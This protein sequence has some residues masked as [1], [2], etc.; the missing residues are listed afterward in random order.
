MPTSVLAQVGSP[1]AAGVTSAAVNRVAK[2]ATT[3]NLIRVSVPILSPSKSSVNVA[4]YWADRSMSN[5]IDVDF[6]K[7]AQRKCQS[8]NECMKRYWSDNAVW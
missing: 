6:S 2:L 4:D 3:S 8:K 7:R 1:P 5:V